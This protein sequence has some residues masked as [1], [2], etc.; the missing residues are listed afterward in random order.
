MPNLSNQNSSGNGNSREEGTSDPSWIAATIERLRAEH[1]ATSSQA[2]KAILLHEIGL[3]EERS[4]DEAGAAR[5]QLQAVNADSTFR[6]P[7]ERLITIIERR[8]SFK[9]LGR[10]LDRLLKISERPGERARALLDNAAFFHDH[11]EDLHGARQALQ[12][13]TELTPEDPSLWLALEYV[14]WALED[15]DLVADALNQRAN[16]EQDPH[17]RGLLLLDLA[18]MR[19]EREEHAEAIGAI[20]QAVEVKGPA[21]FRA[22]LALER[23]ARAAARPELA[24]RALE[25]Q[26]TL[27]LSGLENPD[28]GA[29]LGIP[30]QRL[31][32]THAADAWLRAAEALRQHGDTSQAH[33]LLGRAL[34]RLPEEPS[35]LHARMLTAESLGNTQQAAE[36]AQLELNAGVTGGVA[37]SLWLRVAE[38]AASQGD[39][40]KA[41]EAVNAALGHDAGSIPARV[42]QLDLLIGGANPGALASA[43]EAAAAELPTDEAKSRYFLAAADAWARLAGDTQGAKAALSQAGMFGASPGVVAR[44][45]RM[46]A[47]LTQDGS[48]FEEA[49]RRLLAAGAEPAEQASLWFELGR[50]RLLRGDLTGARDAFASLSNAPGGSWLGP[51][52]GAFVLPLAPRSEDAETESPAVDTSAALTQLTSSETDADARRAL[53]VV[54]AIRARLADDTTQARGALEALHEAN[55]ADALVAAALASLLSEAQEFAGA[56]EALARCANT[57]DDPQLSAA[58]NLECGLLA[59][60]QANREA[61]LDDFAR[62]VDL[63]AGAAGTLLAWALRAATPDDADAR[64]RALEAASEAQ[65]EDPDALAALAIERWGVEF[66]AGGDPEDGRSALASIDPGATDEL[67][68]AADLARALGEDEAALERLGA[69]GDQASTLASA[70][71]YQRAL[72]LGSSAGYLEELAARWAERHNELGGASAHHLDP[73][74]EWLGQAIAAGNL[75]HEVE[76]RRQVARGLSGDARAALDASAGL[77]ELL[78]GNARSPLLESRSVAARLTNLELAPPGS[79]PRRRARALAGVDDSLG[80]DTSTLALALAGWNQIA[81]GDLESAEDSFRAV[82]EALPTEILGWEGLRATAD[83]TGDRT[84]MAEACAAL[85]DAV[86]DTSLGAELWERSALILLDE[87]GDA[88]RGELALARTIERDIRRDVAFDRLFRI[89]RARKDGP[90]LLEL[91]ERRLEVA[92]D[93]EEIAKLFWE[94]ARVMRKAGDLEGALTALENVTMLEAEHVGALALMGEIAI[95]TRRFEEAAEYLGRLAELDEAPAKQRLMSGVAAVDL[96]EKKLDNVEQALNVLSALYKAGL[97]TLPVR[98]RLAR[99]AGKVGAWEQATEVLEQLMQERESSEGRIEAAR[100]A[101]AI[102]RDRRGK[103]EDAAFAVEKLLSESPQDGEALD[104]LLSGLMPEQLQVKLV[105]R[106]RMTL[107]ESVAQNPTDIEVVNRLARVAEVMS[108]A[109][110]RQAALGALTALGAGTP[111]LDRE[112]HSLDQRVARTPQMAIEPEAFPELFDPN[113]RG[114]IVDLMATLA[115]VFVEAIGPSLAAFGV[116]KKDRIDPRAGVP[117]RNELAAWTGALGVGDFDLYV[118]GPDPHGISAIPSER[119]AIVIGAQVGAPFDP[120]RRALAAREIFALRRGSTLLRHR[121]PTDIAALVVAACRVAGVQVQSPAYAMLGEFERQL[122]KAMPR[123]LKKVLPNLAAAF[124]Q[125]GQ[126][127]AQWVEA[128]SGTLDRMGAIAAGDVSQVSLLIENG[129][130]GVPPQ[131]QLGQR[132]LHNLLG[133]VLSPAYLDLRA[134]LGMGVR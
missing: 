81:A 52:L 60:R 61:A 24:A 41:L 98:E 131:T 80:D 5:D 106:A 64:R 127:P 37:A 9:N 86:A 129:A 109:P 47:A 117:Q 50:L 112:L 130:R 92:E 111:E 58:L 68:H 99:A 7:L 91:I 36:L 32:S 79:D 134:R 23:T 128:A 46:L 69:L 21:T 16:L 118:G 95:S 90:T 89:V 113:D 77:L 70:S 72:E 38:A 45:A 3:L 122:S 18:A 102:H 31:T 26:A 63:E 96:Y 44:V 121:D 29:A 74:L 15:H 82:T 107:V 20:E 48:W 49:T 108:D 83:L 103:P 114:P 40:P 28:A 62:S 101:M 25:A 39:G 22:L 59:W 10:L 126:D 97:S 42:L 34:E 104:L 100:L 11:G 65:A 85:G 75:D 4:G 67:T 87:L 33:E 17:W 73:N 8:K 120:A 53:Q 66:A 110:M 119:P 30:E 124:A 51:A 123:K 56:R 94:R 54:A 76:A 27:I 105:P 2:A 133:F 93:P 35:L 1:D 57:T 84:M 71:A 115:P 125:S 116:G 12:E 14:A 6:E 13:A 78:S 43:L 88:E 132:R 55:P 19:A